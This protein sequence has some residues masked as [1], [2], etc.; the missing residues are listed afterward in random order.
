MFLES[1]LREYE[2]IQ[3]F[4]ESAPEKL[5]FSS[6]PE[7][8]MF[9]LVITLGGDGTI[10]WAHK[11]LNRENLPPFVCFDGGSLCFLCNFSNLN[12]KDVLAQV[13]EKVS[14]DVEFNTFSL[15]RLKGYVTVSLI[16]R[17][18]I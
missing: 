8:D 7:T 3:D 13:S 9:D 11:I 15:P 6:D 4:K 17:S 12:V 1:A 16:P 2:H 10:L 14:K 5:A 18:D